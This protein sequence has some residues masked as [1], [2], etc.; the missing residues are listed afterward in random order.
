MPLARRPGDPHAG[1]D[2]PHGKLNLDIS[3]QYN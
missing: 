3:T 2:D 1:A